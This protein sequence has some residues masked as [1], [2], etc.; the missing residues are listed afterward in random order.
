MV[1]IFKILR[2]INRRQL[3]FTLIELMVAM[4]ISGVITGAVTMT[5]FQIFD[6]SGRTSTHMTAVRQVRSAG[7]WVS[8]DVLM[9]QDVVIAD[10]SSD[11][12]DGSRFPV[13]LTWSDWTDNTTHTVVYSIVGDE[14][15]RAHSINSGAPSTGV[16]AEFIDSTLDGDG[17]RKTR[18]DYDYT[19]GKFTLTVT[20][21]VG[22]GSAAQTEAR[23]YE[24]NPRPG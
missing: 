11:D 12:P 19:D 22:A 3:G 17:K 2:S 5:I 4:A 10:E 8:H 7:Y 15:Q 21:T 18:C 23:T 24:V 16:M 14:L 6:S 1:K 13:T 20:A 9:A